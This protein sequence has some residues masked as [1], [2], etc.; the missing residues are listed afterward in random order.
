MPRLCN[1][2]S[3]WL[4]SN[5]AGYAKTGLFAEPRHKLFI[6]FSNV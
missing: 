6:R 5:L 4:A 3:L 2:L 1:C